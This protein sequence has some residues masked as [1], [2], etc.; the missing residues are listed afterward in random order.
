M[1]EGRKAHTEDS[2][3]HPHPHLT[4]TEPRRRALDCFEAI[5]RAAWL[6]DPWGGPDDVEGEEGEEDDD[7]MSRRWIAHSRAAA[8]PTAPPILLRSTWR[9]LSSLLGA[10]GGDLQ[11]EV[12]V[13]NCGDS[14]MGG[15]GVWGKH[16][17]SY[18]LIF[19]TFYL[20]RPPRRKSWPTRA[21]T[22][23]SSPSSSR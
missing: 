14:G 9:A 6:V 2:H 17:D 12:R 13:C 21:R 7:V 10:L 5:L 3:I 1:L 11:A 23:I 16:I 22:A 19:S 18:I 4:A 20:S 15:T 8:V